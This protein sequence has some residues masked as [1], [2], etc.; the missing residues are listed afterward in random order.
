MKRKKKQLLNLSYVI[1]PDTIVYPGDPKVK[2][3]AHKTIPLN[4]SNVLEITYGTH[5]ATHLDAPRHMI[6][7]GNTVIDLKIKNYFGIARCL[8]LKDLC[9][10]VYPEAACEDI[11][12]G[13]AVFIDTGYGHLWNTKDFYGNWPCLANEVLKVLVRK[14]ITAFGIDTPSVDVKGDGNKYNHKILLKNNINVYESLAN[15]DKL[16]N[17]E[18]FVYFSSPLGID[19]ADGVPVSILALIG[20]ENLINSIES[21]KRSI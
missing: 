21:F 2:F 10:S 18:P 15:L 16:P 11:S 13:E 8:K 9:V 17:N 6:A 20:D 14:R 12:P 4:G 1:T 19:R 5:T 3:R 7:G